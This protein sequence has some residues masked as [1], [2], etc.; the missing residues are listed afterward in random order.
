MGGETD[1]AAEVRASTSRTL[2][3]VK[4]RRAALRRQA[5]D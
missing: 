4:T 5:R 3:K 1:P 2:K